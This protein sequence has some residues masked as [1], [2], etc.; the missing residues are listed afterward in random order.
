MHFWLTSAE[1]NGFEFLICCFLSSDGT[2]PVFFGKLVQTFLISYR[3]LEGTV[4]FRPLWPL[5][6]PGEVLNSWTMSKRWK[7]RLFKGEKKKIPVAPNFDFSETIQ[8][9]MKTGKAK[10]TRTQRLCLPGIWWDKISSPCSWDLNCEARNWICIHPQ[11]RWLVPERV[12][13]KH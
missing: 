12:R 1:K 13:L 9:C 2:G 4:V 11:E 3:S 6:V 7:E 5:W 8:K 10:F